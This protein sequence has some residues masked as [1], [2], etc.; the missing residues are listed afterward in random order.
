M[1][2]AVIRAS[3]LT[4]TFGDFVAVDGVDL[5]VQPGECFGML[6]PNGAGKTSTM[7]M[8]GCVTP[9]T[10][11]SLSVLGSDVTARGAG[12]RV[13]A[14]LGVVP[15]EDSLDEELTVE[16]NLVVYARYFGIRT[17]V[18]RQRAGEQLTFM[19]L[20]DRAHDK[21]RT[22]SGGMKRRLVIARALVNDPDVVL[23][24]E[25]TTGLDPQARHHIWDR[26]RTL[27][28]S[29][30]TLVLTTH[31]ME[32]ATQLCDRLVIMDGGRVLVEG[33]PRELVRRCVPRH[34]VEV[35]RAAL[36]GR[37]MPALDGCEVI[38]LHDRVLV[39]T[40][41]GRAVVSALEGAGIDAEDVY[42]RPAS[43][44]DVFLA[45]TGR[46]LLDAGDAGDAAGSGAAPGGDGGP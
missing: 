43:L 10:S 39:H 33:P 21:V 20:A 15:Q 27:G 4:K 2:A 5:E 19:S 14:R 9:V 1:S 40:D 8:I 6:G 32:E 42:A 22:L 23:L 24:D 35:S 18:A 7:R 38:D 45:L 36:D 12:R 3:G 44:E 37:A 13:K 17:E 11:G 25:P 41:D 26:L 30:A 34:V 29:G 46:D 16:E 28:A 31:Y